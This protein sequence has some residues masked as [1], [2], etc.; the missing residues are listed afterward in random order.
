MR[1]TV[2]AVFVVIC[3][4][5]SAVVATAQESPTPTTTNIFEIKVN[6]YNQI[7]D[8]LATIAGLQSD[9]RRPT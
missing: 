5:M 8:R 6:C 2:V 3:G 4:V 7:N 1:R 9:V